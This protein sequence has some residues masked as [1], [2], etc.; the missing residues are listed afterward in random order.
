MKC[1]TCRFWEDGYC[2]SAPGRAMARRGTDTVCRYFK[3]IERG[4]CKD[5]RFSFDYITALTGEPGLFCAHGLHVWE[6]ENMAEVSLVKRGV[7]GF[8]DALYCCFWEG[9]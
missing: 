2:E 6:V 9:A 4:A 8:V 7:D 3:P 1:E 5:C